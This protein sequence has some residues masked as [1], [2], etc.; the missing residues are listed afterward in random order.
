MLNQKT[1]IITVLLTMT[2]LFI[3]Y[4]SLAQSSDL[5]W[6]KSIKEFVDEAISLSSQDPVSSLALFKEILQE[7]NKKLKPNQ[8]VWLEQQISSLQPQAIDILKRDFETAAGALDLRGMTIA[9][10]LANGIVKD[11]I[12]NE[13][14]MSET[15]IKLL[16]GTEGVKFIWKIDT[17][18]ATFI[19]GSYNEESR[20]LTISP[21]E[22]HQ[23]LRVRALIE[24]ISTEPDKS[25]ALWGMVGFKK[26]TIS[27]MFDA[28]K[29]R[30]L[31]DSFIYVATTTSE[32][33]PCMHVSENSGLGFLTLQFTSGELVVPPKPIEKEKKIDIDVFFSVPKERNEYR[34]FILGAPPIN[35]IIS[36]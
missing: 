5:K 4:Q 1:Q 22:G 10:N 7:R 3:V 25:Y 33:I 32:L 34:L 8:K 11:S 2:I 24:N 27:R 20:K 19:K 26:R 23:L 12:K 6:H 30:W 16:S 9:F 21:R 28:S 35:L 17:V 14:V 13:P 18:M 31:D 29:C 36:P 15:K